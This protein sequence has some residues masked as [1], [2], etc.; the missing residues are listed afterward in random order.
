MDTESATQSTAATG[1]K[2]H[3]RSIEEMQKQLS[4]INKVS[5]PLPDFML[6]P[7]DKGKVGKPNLKKSTALVMHSPPPAEKT[8][9]GSL[10]S[11][12]KTKVKSSSLLQGPG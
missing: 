2:S 9:M 6:T 8:P 1:E 7:K 5:S 11:S 3:I 4:E 10:G 12:E